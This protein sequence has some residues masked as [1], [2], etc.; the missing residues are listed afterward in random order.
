MLY[1]LLDVVNNII[2]SQ[3]GGK[4]TLLVLLDFSRAFDCINI[5]LMLAKLVFYGFDAQAVRWFESYF[6]DRTQQVRLKRSD[7]SSYI[8]R[9]YKVERGVPQGSILGPLLFIIYSSDIIKS[10]K[11][12]KF[13]LYA[14]DLQIYTHVSN[15]DVQLGVALLNE[16]LHR[17]SEWAT[18]NCLLLNPNKSKYMILG[19]KQHIKLIGSQRPSIHIHG[20]PIARVSEARNLGL[21]MDEELRFETHVAEL[22]RNCFYR[23]KVLYNIRQFLN[24]NMRHK[25][26]ETLILSKLNYCIGVYGPCLLQK[27]Y[28]MLQRVQNACIRYCLTVPPR[29]HVTP[30]INKAGILKIEARMKLHLSVLLF[31]VVKTHKPAYL[32]TELSWR[33][34]LRRCTAPLLTPPYR[35]TKF[36]GCF[37]YMATK[38]WN[39]I[40]PPIRDLINKHTFKLRFRLY[41][42]AVQKQAA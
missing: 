38:C 25:L 3:D 20:E 17:I 9:P 1:A 28:K 11:N 8:S 22:V 15:N 27:T 35:T 34:S 18:R 21:I 31:G 12:C 29:T 36:R 37:K 10:I 14:D 41:L 26:C 2:C 7:G 40:P 33:N 39:N 4:G 13:H 19:S 32:F 23:L 5:P 30:F 24:V 6:Q 42:L 16:D